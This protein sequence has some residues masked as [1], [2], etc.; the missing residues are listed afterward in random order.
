MCENSEGS[1][2]E[3]NKEQIKF[4]WKPNQL[5]KAWEIYFKY[6]SLQKMVRTKATKQ[7]SYDGVAIGYLT[8]REDLPKPEEQ[9][10]KNRGEEARMNQTKDGE[11]AQQQKT[12]LAGY[13]GFTGN[14]KVPKVNRVIDS[15]GIFP[16]ASMWNFTKKSM[17]TTGFRWEQCWHS[18][19][20]Q[21]LT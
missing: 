8:K 15:Q 4:E 3:A 11:G 20:P 13:M 12:I 5:L 18:M 19:K 6:F 9:N 21:N 14:K 17:E 7:T 2:T 1:Y 16:E 10:P